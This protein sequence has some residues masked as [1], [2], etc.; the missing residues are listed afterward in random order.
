MPDVPRSSPEDRVSW[1]LIGH[2][3]A[4]ARQAVAALRAPTPPRRPAVSACGVAPSPGSS[5]GACSPADASLRCSPVPRVSN[6]ER[7]LE[8]F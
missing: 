2:E 1:V 8:R 3:R 4:R 5:R 7:S 6:C